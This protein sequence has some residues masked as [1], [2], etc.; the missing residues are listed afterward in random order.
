MTVMTV[1]TVMTIMAVE[2][3]SLDFQPVI[4]IQ[5]DLLIICLAYCLVIHWIVKELHAL[6][7]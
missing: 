7:K 1:I 6:Q 2:R 5:N 4:K 3:N